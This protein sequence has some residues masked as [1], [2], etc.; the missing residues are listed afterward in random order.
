MIRPDD[1]SALNVIAGTIAEI[2]ASHGAMAEVRLD[3]DGE[4]LTARL[5]RASIERLGLRRGSPVFALIK[6][7]AIERRS[8]GRS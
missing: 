7:V 3:C 5:T 8:L 4:A 1:I 6:S 2:G